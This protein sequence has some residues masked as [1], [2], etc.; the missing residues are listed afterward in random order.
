MLSLLF[1]FMFGMGSLTEAQ[2]LNRYFRVEARE[3]QSKWF[4]FLMIL[5]VIIIH[6]LITHL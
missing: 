2:R 3:K 6:Y 4:P 5:D 1:Y